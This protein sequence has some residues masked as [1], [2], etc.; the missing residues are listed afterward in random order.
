MKLTRSI[1]IANAALDS[2]LLNG[3]LDKAIENAGGVRAL[4]R[5]LS[6]PHGAMC[7]VKSGKEK[8]SPFR[9]AQLADFMNEETDKAVLAALVAGSQSDLEKRYWQNYRK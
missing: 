3:L 9:A 4:S 7:R 8:I 2:P 6:W 5:S 1:E